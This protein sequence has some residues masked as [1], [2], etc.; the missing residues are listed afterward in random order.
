MT[1]DGTL[2]D[3]RLWA[4]LSGD[5]VGVADGMKVD[6]AGRLFCCGPGG[7]HVFDQEARLLGRIRVPQQAANFAWGDADLLGLFITASQTLYRIRVRVAGKRL[8]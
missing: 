1:A 6:T 7:V 8:Y 3:G 4:E 5:E 2:K